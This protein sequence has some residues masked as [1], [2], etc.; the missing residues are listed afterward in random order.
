MSGRRLVATAILLLAITVLLLIV[1]IPFVTPDTYQAL[2]AGV[3]AAGVI[4]TLG[5][6]GIQF[7]QSQSLAR[8]TAR[9]ELDE[10]VRRTEERARNRRQATL[11]FARA[12][13]DYRYSNWGSLPD[14]FDAVGVRTVVTELIAGRDEDTLRTVMEYLGLLETLSIGIEM[15]IYDADTAYELYGGRIAATAKNYRQLIEWRRDRAGRPSFYVGL[16]SLA[17]DFEGRMER[18]AGVIPSSSS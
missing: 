18:D 13:L 4:V 8:S 9:A 6:I 10:A 7:A 1:P 15:D 2:A 11:E 12:T 16:E 14:D 5:F 3:Q 17:A